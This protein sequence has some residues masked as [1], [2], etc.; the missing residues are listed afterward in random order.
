MVLYVRKDEIDLNKA[1][2]QIEFLIQ[3]WRFCRYD[4]DYS[5]G[6][7]IFRRRDGMASGQV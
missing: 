5:G 6:L 3:V 4:D 7:C 2:S 1:T